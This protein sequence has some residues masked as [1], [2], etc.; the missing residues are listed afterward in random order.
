M[1]TVAAQ[2]LLAGDAGGR[3]PRPAHPG[4]RRAPHD[5]TRYGPAIGSGPGAAP[6]PVPTRNRPRS[7]R[8][9]LTERSVPAQQR[10]AVLANDL[11]MLGRTG[12]TPSSSRPTCRWRR[13]RIATRP[14]RYPRSPIRWTRLVRAYAG[15]FLGL[16]DQADEQVDQVNPLGQQHAAAVARLHAAPGFVVIALG[17]PDMHI[18]RCADDLAQPSRG[19]GSSAASRPP[20]GTGAAGR[21]PVSPP[22]RDRCGPVRPHA[23]RRSRAVSPSGHACPPRHSAEPGRDGCPAWSATSRRPRSDRRA[24]RPDRRSPEI[25]GNFSA[26]AARRDSVRLNAPATSR[27]D[28]SGPAIPGHGA[29][30]PCR[31]RRSR[32]VFSALA[33]SLLIIKGRLQPSSPLPPRQSLSGGRPTVVNN[34]SGTRKT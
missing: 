2:G 3:A 6:P 29:S 1:K 22:R 24:W 27:H 25:A 21:C 13:F 19:E 28:R 9:N 18:D 34:R 31:G 20:G 16:P 12:G 4:N 33:P 30:R 17:P 14:R 5:G 8:G 10:R 7:R 26:K 15:H 32:S 23:R 11:D